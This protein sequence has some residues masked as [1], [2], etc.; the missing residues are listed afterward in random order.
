M[1]SLAV[2]SIQTGVPQGSL[3]GPVLINIYIGDAP[4]LGNGK[5]FAVSVSADVT[6]VKLQAGR[7]R[8]APR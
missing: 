7:T 8:W 1:E 3:L 2:R 4:S 5:N 6:E